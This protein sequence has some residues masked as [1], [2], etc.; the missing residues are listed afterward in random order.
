MGSIWLR[1]GA[2]V[3][4]SILGCDMQLLS[5]VPSSVLAVFAHPDD[6][7]IACGGTLGRWAAAGA[8]CRVVLC[9]RGDK[10]SRALVS[11]PDQFAATRRAEASRAAGIVGTTLTFLGRDD[12]SLTHESLLAELVSR[13]RRDKPDVVIGPD[14]T[15][16]FFGSTYINHPDHRALGW[17][18]LDALS[19]IAANPNYLPEHL[20]SHAVPLVLLAGTLEPDVGVDISTTL[21]HKVEAVLCHASQVRDPQRLAAV[22]RQR[23]RDDG[24]ACATTAAECFRQLNFS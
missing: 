1:V 2:G 23:A 12:G 21:E 14:P 20:G 15:A 9:A 5:E 16:V 13:I 17:A 24:H 10:G 19:P 18:L 11:D 22:V 3:A 8:V 4:M 7:E 6:A